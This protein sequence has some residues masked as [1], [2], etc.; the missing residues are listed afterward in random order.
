MPVKVGVE[1]LEMLKG[2]VFERALLEKFEKVMPWMGEVEEEEG[3][4]LGEIYKGVEVGEK[5]K[6]FLSRQH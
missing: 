3:R 6:R 5:M 1:Y 2:T 4:R